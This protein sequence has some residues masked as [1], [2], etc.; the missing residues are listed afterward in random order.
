MSSD[1]GSGTHFDG[2]IM[3]CDIVSSRQSAA[4]LF[5]DYAEAANK[6][7]DIQNM[8]KAVNIKRQH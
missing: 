7:T 8:I 3:R 6:H 1:M 2:G 5:I 4:L